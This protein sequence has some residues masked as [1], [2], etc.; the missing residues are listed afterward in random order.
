MKTITTYLLALGVLCTSLFPL[1]ASEGWKI[2]ATSRDGYFP[3]VVANGMI[4]I[5]PS[6]RPLHV[7]RVMLNGLY[8]NGDGRNQGVVTNFDLNNAPVIDLVLKNT[9]KRTS[10]AG[11]ADVQS[12]QQTMDMRNA[13]IITTFDLYETLSM[14]HRIMALRHLPFNYL[15]E[16]TVTALK[17]ETLE[18][19]ISIEDKPY[20]KTI[21]NRFLY[22]HDIPL[23]SKTVASPAENHQITVVNSVM[24]D[25]PDIPLLSET[26]EFFGTN[27]FT[28]ELKKGETF[29]FAVLTSI[30]SSVHFE[31]HINEAMRF[32]IFGYLEGKDRLIQKH[33]E[34]WAELWKSDIILE[35]NNPQEQL[36]IRFS[37]YNLY[38]Y[39][40]ANTAYSIPPMGLY[41]TGYSGHIFWDAEIWMYP[42]L[43]L[44]QPEMAKSMLEYRYQRMQAAREIA[45]ARGY[46][47]VMFPWES[48]HT[49]YEETPIWALTGPFQHHITADVGIAFWQYYLVTKDI[50]WL[51]EKG[52]PVLKEVAEFWLS[53]VDLN[54][55]GEYEILNVVCPDEFAENVDN[56]AFT[57]AAAITVLRQ[58]T[59][60]A[61]ELGLRPDP[62]W[63]TVANGIPV[64]QFKDGITREHD[65]YNG[66]VI[67]QADVN[68]LAFPLNFITDKETIR[69]DLDYYSK[70]VTSNGPAM[71]HGIFS[72]IANRLGN[73]EEA[74]QYFKDSYIPNQRPPFGALA[75][76]QKSDN[77]YFATG[78]GAM[79]QAVMFGFGGLDFDNKKGI[80]Q[81]TSCLPK[82]WKSL[83]IKGIGT[84]KQTIRIFQP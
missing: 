77:P 64:K 78:A 38:S 10:R 70:R 31:D 56:N 75:E 71:T 76:S 19:V 79:L 26:S 32:N 60:A 27:K 35:S 13:E 24:L 6:T 68:L 48:A 45:H 51:A 12:W 53:R 62:M 41:S 65:S 28:I 8:D 33:R 57:N 25:N 36:D 63:T 66:E 34:A 20:L 40:R 22:V 3:P 59:L 54:E 43:L 58:A 18:F 69:K 7:Q 74:Y 83:T 23:M 17:N 50:Q 44:L 80:V 15:T 52:F 9:Q 1:R 2:V 73:C 55:K 39:I 30:C 4:G 82:S 49:G 61:R 5:L 14:Q 29:S 37:L 47:G 81:K 42:P 11:H 84:E 21:Y 72:V 67:K 16:V 46:K